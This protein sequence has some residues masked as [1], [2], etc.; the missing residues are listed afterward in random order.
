MPDHYAKR[1][2][3]Q[4]TD[5]QDGKASVGL[6]GSPTKGTRNFRVW[7]DSGGYV[8]AFVKTHRTDVLSQVSFTMCQLTPP[9][10][11]LKKYNN[12]KKSKQMLNHQTALSKILFLDLNP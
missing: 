8:A 7:L 3:A 12:V 5:L 1:R 9:Q 10:T 4:D 11:Q 2:A 6:R